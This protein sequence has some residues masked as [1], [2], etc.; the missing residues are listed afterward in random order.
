MADK[1][2]RGK[3]CIWQSSE[4]TTHKYALPRWPKNHL[5]FG[6]GD[7]YIEQ[8]EGSAKY[9]QSNGPKSVW[10]NLYVL[11]LLSSSL[12]TLDYKNSCLAL[13]SNGIQQTGS[14]F[15]FAINHFGPSIG[16]IFITF[17]FVYL[18]QLRII[19][20][21]SRYNSGFIS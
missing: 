1:I 2:S 17:N 3:P 8:K 19:G 6:V 20:L 11:V 16:H 13:S 5:I 4:S 12:R 9:R 14:T 7:N 21:K 18:R 10:T 15:F